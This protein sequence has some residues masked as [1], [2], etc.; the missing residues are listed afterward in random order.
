M[1]RVRSPNAPCKSV[2]ACLRE[3][4]SAKAGGIT[5]YKVP[6]PLNFLLPQFLRY[7]HER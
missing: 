1:G 2:I 7:D 4:A 6:Q 5:P 3:A